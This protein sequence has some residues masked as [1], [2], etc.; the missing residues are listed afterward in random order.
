MVQDWLLNLPLFLM[1]LIVFGGTYLVAAA[2]LAHRDKAR[3]RRPGPCLQGV[4]AGDAAAARHHL[5][6]SRRLHRRAGVERFR[7]GEA[8]GLQRSERASLRHHPG[9]KISQ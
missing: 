7:E 4:V 8:R 6:S 5:R 3:G 2:H 1:A 9:A